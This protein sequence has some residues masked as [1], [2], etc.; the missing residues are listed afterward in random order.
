[1]KQL[2]KRKHTTQRNHL[3]F[4]LSDKDKQLTGYCKQKYT[5]FKTLI[6]SIEIR[7][8]KHEKKLINVWTILD[9][10]NQFLGGEKGEMHN[11]F[12]VSQRTEAQQSSTELLRLQHINKCVKRKLYKQVIK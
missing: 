1:M 4:W 7:F 10:I 12:V 8:N 3:I 11:Q 9:K 2:F 5:D 6:D